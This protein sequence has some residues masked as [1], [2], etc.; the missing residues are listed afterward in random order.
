MLNFVNF[1]THFKNAYKTSGNS[2]KCKKTNLIISVLD[3]LK[4]RN[5]INSYYTSGHDIIVDIS[6]CKIHDLDLI[7]K[8]SKKISAKKNSF[9]FFYS[10]LASVI[11]TTSAG[12]LYSEE[13]KSQNY[14]GFPLMYII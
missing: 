11:V 8:P 6:G 5:F 10:G 4:K 13:A 7:Y 2:F 3:I 14:G 1:V 9:P 12:V